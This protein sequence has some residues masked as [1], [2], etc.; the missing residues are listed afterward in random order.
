MSENG[1]AVEDIVKMLG[2]WCCGIAI[3]AVV[4]SSISGSS[5][6]VKIAATIGGMMMGSVAGDVVADKCVEDFKDN[7][8]KILKAVN[9]E[10][11]VDAN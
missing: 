9:E 11:F 10:K 1:F 4:A 8:A 5:V 3:G 6:P 2:S 7:A